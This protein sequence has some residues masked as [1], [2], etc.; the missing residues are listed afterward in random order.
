MPR[1][2]NGSRKNKLGKCV[3]QTKKKYKRKKN[4]RLTSKKQPEKSDCAKLFEL[5]KTNNDLL[6][7]E[8]KDFFAIKKCQ[9]DTNRQVLEQNKFP[10]LYPHLDDANFTQK[11]TKKK[12]FFDTRS[13][14]ITRKDIN[15]IEKES[16]KI[17]DPDREFELAP[18]QMFVRNFLSFQTPYNSLLLFHGLGTGK[19]CSSISVCEEMRL[20]LN[21]LGVK[22]KIIIV[23]SPA[24]QT[25][26][27]LQLFDHRKL[28][29]ING[30]WNL[31]SCT[32]NRFI[33]EINPM[34][35]KGL[36]RDKLIQQ[37]DKIINQ[38]YEFLGYTGFANYINNIIIKNLPKNSDNEKKRRNK[39]KAI[40]HEFSNRLITI[41][42]VH[43]IRNVDGMKGTSEKFLELVTYA[44]NMKLLLLTA[45]PMFNDYKEIIW[46]TNL[47]NLNDNRYPILISDVFD[48]DGKFKKINGEEIG[49][50]LLIQKLTGY[51]SYVKGENPF[52]FPY[53]IWPQEFQNPYSLASILKNKKYPTIQINN[54]QITNPIRLLDLIYLKIGTYQ[55]KGYD[56]ILDKIKNILKK[57]KGL[58]YTLLD[59]PLQALNM[60][61]PHE[62]LD[63][64]SGGNISKFLYGKKGLSRLMYFKP[65]KKIGEIEYKSSTLKKWGPI[66][67]PKNLQQYSKKIHYIMTQ[68]QQSKGIVMIYSQFIDGGCVPLALALEEIGI[69]RYG[70]KSNLFKK[71]R[72]QAI[73]ALTMSSKQPV[74]Y[75]AK[76][77]MITGDKILSG[78][79]TSVSNKI[80]LDACTNI[81]N[82][83]GEQVKVVI[84]SKAGSEGLDFANIRQIHI[85]EPW[86]NLNRTDQIIGRAVRNKSHCRLPYKE[87]NVQIYLYG[88]ELEDPTKEAADMYLYRFAEKK[89]IQI[90]NVSRLLKENAIDCLLNKNSHFSTEKNMNKKVEQLLSSGSTIEFSLGDKNNS[91]ICDFMDCEYNCKPNNIVPKDIDNSTYNEN[92]IIMNIDKILQRIRLL[93]K[94]KHV[95]KKNDLIASINSIKMYP[96]DQIMTALEF[97]I[98]NNNEYI[99]DYI[100]HLGKLINRGDYYLFQP[101]EIENEGISVFQ[102]GRHPD[103]KRNK[104]QFLAPKN[105]QKTSA[106][107]LINNNAQ[108]EKILKRI[109]VLIN[110]IKN[111]IEKIE[112]YNAN[113]KSNDWGYFAAWSVYSLHK[114][115]KLDVGILLQLCA[116]HL[117]DSLNYKDKILIASYIY[118]K[119]TMESVVS[120]ETEQ[121]IKTFFDALVLERKE[122]KGIVFINYKLAEK[123]IESK[124]SILNISQDDIIEKDR[125]TVASL[126]KL[127]FDKFKIHDEEINDSIGFMDIFKKQ[128]IVCKLKTFSEQTNKYKNRGQACSKGD[129]K[130]NIINRIN[131]LSYDKYKLKK[132]IIDTISD[133]DG[134]IYHRT[135]KTGETFVQEYIIDKSKLKHARITSEQLCV[136]NELLL[137]YNDFIK[138]D[139]KRWFFSTVESARNNL[140]DKNITIK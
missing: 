98:N 58:Q 62:N 121:L 117:L 31:K 27:R 82:V 93:F 97:L 38:S 5:I 51:V 75:P 90:G 112:Y 128:D 73:D 116:D 46:L 59:P 85:L 28:K 36:S 135:K 47:M 40:R 132:S 86:Y 42:E 68:I 25:N 72:T 81:D 134:K 66:F 95:Y 70:E 130:Q 122:I 80:E 6:K 29:N 136:E 129:T 15:N 114:Y 78:P 119:T 35:M 100:G 110:I 1:C 34:Q 65:K 19:T 10:F 118:K 41:D 11:I 18:H 7:L 4:I 106:V 30:M 37:I 45:T 120:Q 137:R 111:P 79:R 109:E 54:K 16:E 32:G 94:E 103:F 52:A 39:I 83:N 56:Y 3:S 124:I 71:E 57:E 33:N 26:Y 22:K 96:D 101:I 20:Y 126:G 13:K 131:K 12:E 113:K 67:S 125:T 53:R 23:A 49:K 9:S 140:M 74:N 89:G 14:K 104:L 99:V 44:E 2:P 123:R 105:F 133:V 138:K 92:F 24:V 63:K 50:E 115:N 139:G 64:K 84:I 48:S 127:V 77:I 55:Q 108:I 8:T 88:T 107:S 91:I 60:V 43:N 102:R 61:Y 21:Q 69:T 87:R 76:Y 17:C